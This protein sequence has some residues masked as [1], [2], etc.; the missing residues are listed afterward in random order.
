MLDEWL[1]EFSRK[2]G[3]DYYGVA[4]LTNAENFIDQQG[5]ISVKQYPRAVSLGIVLLDTIIDDLPMR[6]EN[7]VAVNYKHHYDMVNLRLDLIASRLASIIQREGYKAMPVPASE[8]CDDKRISALFSH[9]LA[10]NLAGLG[11]IGKNCLLIT[12]E[13]GPRVRWISILTNAPLHPTGSPMKNQCGDCR[14]CVDIC[15]VDAFT[16]KSFRI[17][18]ER[19]VRYDAKKCEEYF[20]LM[21]EA[22]NIPVCGLCIYKCPS[23]T[24]SDIK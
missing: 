3:A 18:D 14:E 17:E 5:R 22:G 8:R 1:D 13:S 11:W 19:E 2:L 21:E 7:C 4:D 10:A 9:K 24:K 6:F 15:P 12:P 16:G 20:E 23:G